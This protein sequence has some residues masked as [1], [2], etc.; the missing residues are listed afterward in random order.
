MV[1]YM[2][3]HF[4]GEWVFVDSEDK[5]KLD[6]T[7]EFLRLWKQFMLPRLEPL[8]FIEENYTLREK[9]HIQ[10]FKGEYIGKHDIL[11]LKLYMKGK[12]EKNKISQMP[13][14]LG[15]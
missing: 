6:E 3:D 2:D 7:Y 4:Y 10:N 5:D 1:Q 15:S 9:K 12:I 11:S 8:E 14:Q 13:K